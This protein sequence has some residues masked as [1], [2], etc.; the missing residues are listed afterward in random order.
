MTNV[1]PGLRQWCFRLILGSVVA[2]LLLACGLLLVLIADTQSGIRAAEGPIASRFFDRWGDEVVTVNPMM[3]PTRFPAH[4]A[5]NEFR[6]FVF[7]G[8]AAMGSPY[9][10]Q[11]FN[12]ATELLG[13]LKFPN[14]GGISTWLQ[15]YLQSAMPGR[16]VRVINAA[17]GANDIAVAFR[18]FSEALEIGHPDAVFL[19]SGNNQR[20]P[21]ADRELLSADPEANLAAVVARMTAEFSAVL[22]AFGEYASR[23]GVPLFVATVPVNLRDWE[24]ADSGDNGRWKEVR[25]LLDA[26]RA[27]GAAA[28]LRWIH[29][30]DAPDAMAQYLWGRCF[31]RL[32]D[33]EQAHRHYSLARDHDPAFMRCR[34][35]WNEAIRRSADS[36]HLV[37]LERYARSL[38]RDGLP[39]FDLFHDFCHMRLPVNVVVGH[40]IAR[41]MLA[42]L[43]PGRPVPSIESADFSAFASR[44]L[45]TLYLLKRLKWLRVRI[46]LLG[47]RAGGANAERAMDAYRESAMIAG[48]LETQIRDIEALSRSGGS[49][50][51]APGP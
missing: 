3:V 24:P 6:V 10:H 30:E 37:D 38:A 27:G 42:A 13:C 5:T 33:R 2:V 26:G 39:G 32:G 12:R 40:E 16:R 29:A 25:E 8:S 47:A 35:P 20:P 9:V 22:G 17:I 45:K 51:W 19:M 1:L 4:K 14:E 49:R 11:S 21:E 41:T 31:D 28:A 50:S 23:A 36:A 7:G 18:V 44:H 48:N 46:G 15:Q 34:A 43:F